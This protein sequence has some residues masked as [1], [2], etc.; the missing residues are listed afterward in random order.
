MWYE[1]NNGT[2]HDVKLFNL[3]TL[4]YYINSVHNYFH[5]DDKEIH[6]IK[7]MNRRDRIIYLFTFLY[8]LENI[9]L[10]YNEKNN[11]LHMLLEIKNVDPRE[12]L[13]DLYK[14]YR[15]K[16]GIRTPDKKFKTLVGS[17]IDDELSLA[18]YYQIYE[19]VSIIRS[20]FTRKIIKFQSP[21]VLFH[22]PPSFVDLNNNLTHLFVP[23]VNNLE[24]DDSS[25]CIEY[26]NDV[27][28]NSNLK[29]KKMFEE[30]YN[31]LILERNKDLLN[32]LSYV[33]NDKNIIEKLKSK[34]KEEIKI[35]IS[36]LKNFLKV[37]GYKLMNN[38]LMNG[39]KWFLS[40]SYIHVY[41]DKVY[42]LSTYDVNI[43]K[44]NPFNGL[45]INNYQRSRM[46]C[47]KLNE[48]NKYK[49]LLNMNF[50]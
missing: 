39:T 24:V 4:I 9:E 49:K 37:T 19:L 33:E 29:N 13:L 43:L 27:M 30:K 22:T 50:S 26:F 16:P 38:N 21:E 14:L 3:P 5:Y 2:L 7:S 35:N 15:I 10:K 11:I 36:F 20:I 40:D 48:F 25:F 41:Q 34:I 45:I 44:M 23:I 46:E 17:I 12:I 47:I 31:E 32:F 28:N 18:F 1:V 8:D 6:I 42:L